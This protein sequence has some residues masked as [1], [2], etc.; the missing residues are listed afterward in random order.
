MKKFLIAPSIL[1]SNLKNLEKI[2]KEIEEGGADLIH[3]DIMDGHFVPNIT[4]GPFFV[5]TIKE[6]CKIPVDVHL[7][8]ENPE[9]YFEKFIENG[10]DW[11]IIHYEAVTH[12]D[13]LLKKI[14]EMGAKNGVAFNPSTPVFLLK[15]I[16][17]LV[18][19][20][21]VMGVNPGFSGQE[22]IS[23]TIKKVKE[24]KEIKI[25]KKYEYLIGFDGGVKFENA[26]KILKNGCDVLM[27]GSGIFNE[28]NIAKAIKKFKMISV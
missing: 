14:K 24:L 3:I 16:L 9:K 23:Y 12:L 17:H 1:A 4:V 6:L 26:K 18:D 25:Q 11:V 8:I 22:I 28:D 2:V 27:I 21:L 19:M 13:F 20:A 7:M 5:K 15:E 10:A